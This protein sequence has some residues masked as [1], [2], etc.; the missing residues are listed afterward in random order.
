MWD[1][2]QWKASH[3]DH[4][5]LPPHPLSPAASFKGTLGTE[6]LQAVVYRGRAQKNASLQ[7]TIERG[8]QA[9]PTCL[10]SVT[11]LKQKVHKCPEWIQFSY[12]TIL[13]SHQGSD[14][15]DM[16][17]TKERKRIRYFKQF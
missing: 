2:S 9:T 12:R 3:G 13:C 6:A 15:E 4:L 7:L 1:L 8:S 5:S 10:V 14:R 11:L 16:E 17:G